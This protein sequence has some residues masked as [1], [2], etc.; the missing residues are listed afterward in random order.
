MLFNLASRPSPS[1]NRFARRRNSAGHTNGTFFQSLERLEDRALFAVTPL[2]P[3]AALP[4][5][6]VDASTAILD[7]LVV[8]GDS[9][10]DTGDLF[11]MIGYPPP[12]YVEGRFSNG[13]VWAEYLAASLGLDLTD[14]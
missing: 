10:S 4:E 1:H 6:Q 7:D 2:A 5:A 8:F 9:L 14:E 11:E 13:L 12:P 3:L